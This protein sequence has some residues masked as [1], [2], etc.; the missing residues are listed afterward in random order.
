[1]K[2]EL[3]DYSVRAS[4]SNLT[5]MQSLSQYE[6]LT[7]GLSLAGIDNIELG[8]LSD[9]KN[10]FCKPITDSIIDY[11][12][13]AKEHKA[14]YSVMIHPSGY[15]C[16]K[17]PKC[18]GTIPY[19][20]VLLKKDTMD[21]VRKMVEII[22]EKGYNLICD[23]DDVYGYTDMEILKLCGYL[24]F[25]KPAQVTIVDDTNSLDTRPVRRVAMLLDNNLDE[26]V[27]IAL[28]TGINTGLSQNTATMFLDVKYQRNRTVVLESTLLGI[29]M[30]KGNLCTEVMAD[31]LNEDFGASYDYDRLITLISLFI[32]KSN[33]MPQ[34]GGYH[35]AYYIAAKN[36]VDAE[37][38]KYFLGT[39][40]PLYM[41]ND[42]MKI[43]A[44]TE[45]FETFDEDKAKVI[46]QKFYTGL[47]V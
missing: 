7:M 46:V 44:E 22:K 10:G 33:L 42:I 30:I 28:R 2:I 27:K 39:G 40:I 16:R 37:Y 9:E 6:Y 32:P 29:G 13:L 18:S 43:V 34:H 11:Y 26:S 31:Q 15:D 24:A 47:C 8:Y 25:I 23:I 38:A 35:P 36:R 19:I 45:Q 1:M 41:L 21:G 4:M 20:R 17:L 3:L 14:S 12:I 5:D